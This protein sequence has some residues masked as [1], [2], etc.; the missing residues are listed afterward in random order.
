VLTTEIFNGVTFEVI[1]GGDG[2]I[3]EILVFVLE[4]PDP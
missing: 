2:R 1:F 4:L 3:G